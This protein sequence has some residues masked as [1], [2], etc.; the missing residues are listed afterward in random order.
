MHGRRDIIRSQMFYSVYT[1]VTHCKHKKT[2]AHTDLSQSGAV[3]KLPEEKQ[4]NM[5][6]DR[7]LRSN[8]AMADLFTNNSLFFG[9]QAQ[10]LKDNQR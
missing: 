10:L 9:M 1:K 6:I 2:S 4:K 5:N 8:S 3:N 7:M